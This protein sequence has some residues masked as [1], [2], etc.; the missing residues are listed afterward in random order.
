MSVAESAVYWLFQPPALQREFGSC[1]L[2]HSSQIGLRKSSFHIRQYCILKIAWIRFF[3]PSRNFHVIRIKYKYLY[4]KAQR[5]NDSWK[6][7]DISSASL[8]VWEIAECSVCITHYPWNSGGAQSPE[9]LC[10]GLTEQITRT[11]LLC[12]PLWFDVVQV[13]LWQLNRG[14]T[15]KLHLLLA[16]TKQD[17]GPDSRSKKRFSALCKTACTTTASG[18]CP[19]AS[20]W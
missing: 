3:F 4:R 10:N 5:I 8:L 13:C 14:Q 7:K 12:V 19:S 20:L 2:V 11:F 16:S 1:C 17:R 18:H 15:F 6:V 9:T